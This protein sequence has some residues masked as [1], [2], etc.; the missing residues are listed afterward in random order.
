MPVNHTMNQSIL[1]ESHRYVSNARDKPLV[2]RRN[3][4]GSEA[5]VFYIDFQWMC[6]LI[7]SAC[8][9][10]RSCI[11]SKILHRNYSDGF[12]MSGKRMM[13]TKWG[14]IRQMRGECFAESLKGTLA[15]APLSTLHPPMQLLVPQKWTGRRKVLLSVW[16]G[17]QWMRADIYLSA[18]IMFHGSKCSTCLH[19]QCPQQAFSLEQDEPLVQSLC[20]V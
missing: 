13:G 15:E 16:G 20:L 11:K 1:I 14:Q 18:Q 5:P 12:T 3:L 17:K 7:R 9:M 4:I 8:I 6:N 10:P 19:D 2:S